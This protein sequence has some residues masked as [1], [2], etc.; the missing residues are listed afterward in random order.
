MQFLGCMH[1][2]GPEV[3]AQ[4]HNGVGGGSAL[5]C[6]RQM[7]LRKACAME[8]LA[9]KL[10]NTLTDWPAERVSIV[11]ISVGTCPRQHLSIGFCA[12]QCHA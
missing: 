1:A 4:W 11:W 6:S 10:K 3:R 9:R 7:M 5:A 8:K 2:R 12:F